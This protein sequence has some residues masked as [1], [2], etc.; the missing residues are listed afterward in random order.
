MHQLSELLRV[1]L[2]PA[3]PRIDGQAEYRTN[4]LTLVYRPTTNVVETGATRSRFGTWRQS[5]SKVLVTAGLV[6]LVFEGSPLAFVSL[7]AYAND[8]RWVDATVATPSLQSGGALVL[9]DD[10]A[11]E[12]RM[13]LPAEP[14]FH[15]D[16]K[17]LALRVGLDV[18]EAQR[19]CEIGRNLVAGLTGDRLIELILLNVRFS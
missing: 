13:T 3:I 7:D 11:A 9:T 15:V 19:Y 10:R 2:N 14:T 16:R 12:E 1:D 17:E 6:T 5:G 4:D 18:S 8:Q